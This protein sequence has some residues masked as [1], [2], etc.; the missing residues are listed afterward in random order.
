MKTILM[1]K[2]NKKKLRI[3]M[4]RM[5]GASLIEKYRECFGGILNE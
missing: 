3:K 2:C 4:S 1:I 5:G